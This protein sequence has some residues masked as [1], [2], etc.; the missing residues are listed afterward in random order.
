MVGTTSDWEGRWLASRAP[1]YRQ[2]H[3][4]TASALPEL[5]TMGPR[6]IAA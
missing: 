2:S 5:P 6:G 3:H 1:R 4:A